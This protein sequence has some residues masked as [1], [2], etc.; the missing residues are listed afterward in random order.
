MLLQ[1]THPPHRLMAMADLDGTP[2]TAGVVTVRIGPGISLKPLPETAQTGGQAFD[3]ADLRSWSSPAAIP[4]FTYV[5]EVDV[6][7]DV[8]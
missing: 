7:E 1:L 2:A 8:G 3:T 5:L 6:R 4:P